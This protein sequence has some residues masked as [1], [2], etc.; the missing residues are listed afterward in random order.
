MVLKIRSAIIIIRLKVIRII[1]SVR[2]SRWM[3]QKHM[4]YN[5][6]GLMRI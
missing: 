4:G 5:D 1:I 6:G 3:D 2:R